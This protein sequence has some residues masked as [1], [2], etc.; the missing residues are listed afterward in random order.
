[1]KLTIPSVARTT[2]LSFCFAFVTIAG[3]VSSTA[4]T[5]TRGPYLQ[6]GT[7]NS[8]IV[9][10]RT[11]VAMDSYVRFGTAPGVFTTTLSAAS[12]VTDHALI[13]SGL[14]ADTK[15]YYEIGSSSGWFSGDANDYFVTSPPVGVE[16]STRLWVLG[17][18]G[19]ANASAA[20]VRNAYLTYSSPRPADLLLM[21]GDNAYNS[22]TD[23]EYQA[24]VF[25]MY[26]TTLQ[27]TVLWPTIGNHD[28]SSAY[29][30]I[31]NLPQNGEASGVPSGTEKYYSFDYGNIHFICL[32]SF[33]LSRSSSGAM[34]NWLQ[35]DLQST[36]QQWA[37]AFWHHPPYSKGSHN[38]DAEVELI[39]MRQNFLPLLE[40]Y[41][42]DLVLSGH[43]HAYER[44]FL[45]DG[46]YG[47]SSTFTQAHK[48]D[49]GNGRVNGT[50]AYVK[51][52][53]LT[54]HQGSVYVVA[55][56]S[57]QVSGGALNHP[58][59]FISLNQLGSLVIDINSNRL[60]LV[61][62]K[63]D[64][65][66]GD[67][68]TM[69]KTAPA[70]NPPA[71]PTALSALTISSSQINLSWTDNSVD[72]DGFKVER[73]TNGTDFVQVAIIGANVANGAD[74]GLSPS[75]TYF[76]RVR[77]F[78]AAGDSPYS[79]VAQATTG[80]GPVGATLIASNSV[81]K[82]LAN[83]SDQGTA[84]RAPFFNDAAWASGAA[85]LGYGDGGEATVV[86]FGPNSSAKYITTYFRKSF[87]V[88]GP[89]AYTNLLLQLVRDDGA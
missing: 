43:S 44:S 14:Q 67:Y 29:F 28:S 36:T 76:Y 77:A 74:V 39:E 15:Y 13:V 70:S 37:I 64:G 58:A 54:S 5:V 75:T 34:Y 53:A 17:D 12:T 42:V 51:P 73:S 60:D 38:S 62:L 68:F 71:A 84:W 10:W 63:S 3:V 86:S 47:G 4:A 11:D 72:E 9:C 6:L 45:I 40:A 50:G 83:G 35:A 7:T 21:L 59:M 41:D 79:N 46:H 31:F 1:M 20:A 22:G 30:N 78:N 65:T 16:K 88:T 18:S 2:L 80:V 69:I 56:S 24:G 61:F 81:W 52:A 27:N 89:A 87:T 55:G 48:K 23:S 26:P 57:G 82:Y 49:G 25:N 8:V 66:T 19:T 85:E 32:D 33:S